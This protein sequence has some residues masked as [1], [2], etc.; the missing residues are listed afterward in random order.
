MEFKIG[1]RVR[2]RR[3]EDLPNEIKYRGLGKS[4]GKNGEIIDVMYSNAKDLYVYKLQFD[5]SNRPSTTAFPEGSF[6]LISDLEAAQYTYEFEFL[7]NLV[8]ARLY[9][10][11]DGEKTEIAK[12]HGHVFHNG[13]F[14]IAQAASYAL[15][16]IAS[17]LNGGYIDTRC[18]EGDRQW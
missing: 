9:E 16:R 12:G 15:K 8:V 1:D 2:V 5:D 7:E 10:I 3:Y 18:T 17:D 14:G 6:D 4:A 13:V 11:K